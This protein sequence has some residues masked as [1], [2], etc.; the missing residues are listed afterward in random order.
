MGESRVKKFIMKE[1]LH[2]KSICNKRARNKFHL[3]C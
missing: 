3:T 1:N 2:S